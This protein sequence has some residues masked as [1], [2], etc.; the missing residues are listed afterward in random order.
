MFN[1]YGHPGDIL[2]TLSLA[3]PCNIAL[4]V[5]GFGALLFILRD[6]LGLLIIC[7]LCTGLLTLLLGVYIYTVLRTVCIV[8]PEKK[9]LTYKGINGKVT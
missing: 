1:L 2:P 8:D 6:H 3:T 7:G 9:V 4:I 5:I